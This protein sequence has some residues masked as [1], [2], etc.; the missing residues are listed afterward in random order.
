MQTFLPF[1]DF[2]VSVKCLDNKRLGKQRVEAKQILDVLEGRK[3]GWKNHPAVKMWKGYEE[4]LKFYINC[5][6]DEWISRKNKKGEPFKNTMEYYHTVLDDEEYLEYPW[7][8]GKD[9][10]HESHRSNLL[11]KDYSFYSKY[12]WIELTN[13]PYVWPKGKE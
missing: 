5:C 8:F 11:R 9:K 3:E 10:F 4:A 1:P 7:W 12:G 6:I 2:K 13:L